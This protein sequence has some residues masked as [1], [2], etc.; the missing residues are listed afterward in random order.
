MDLGI[1]ADTREATLKA[2]EQA[3]RQADVILTG[4]SRSGKTPTCLYLSMQFG[5]RAANYPLT[6]EDLASGALPKLL[7][8]HRKR[9]FGLS[10]NP[11]RL[12]QI[13]TE[14]RPNRP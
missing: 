14:R 10:I 3:A 7:A 12:Q 11:E 9:L 8:P 4:V 1:V 5:I 2:L 6:E 13:R